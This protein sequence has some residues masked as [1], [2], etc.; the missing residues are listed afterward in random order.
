V[1]CESSNYFSASKN[2]C[3][4]VR[5]NTYIPIKLI[6][7]QPI[8]KPS[9]LQIFNRKLFGGVAADFALLRW[10]LAV[11]VG[12]AITL[13][14]M[15]ETGADTNWREIWDDRYQRFYYFNVRTNE[16]SWVKPAE[17][18]AVKDLPPPSRELALYSPRQDASLYTKRSLLPQDSSAVVETVWDRLAKP[19]VRSRSTPHQREPEPQPAVPA[20]RATPLHARVRS[21]TA[22]RASPSLSSPSASI[23][24]S[25]PSAVDESSSA[26]PAV[27]SRTPVSA[28]AEKAVAAADVWVEFYDRDEHAP[29]FVQVTTRRRSW[30]RPRD[31]VV[32][33]MGGADLCFWLGSV[34]HLV[35]CSHPEPLPPASPRRS[36]STV[37]QVA[38]RAQ[39]AEPRPP[40][41][42]AVDAELRFAPRINASSRRLRRAGVAETTWEWNRQKVQIY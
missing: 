12:H 27:R 16:S 26:S 34:W 35:S 1:H 4:H 25:I 5:H 41:E 33:P 18:D 7:R 6:P 30:Q 2:K 28:P 17:I 9:R 39:S 3:E 32:V 10:F 36:L 13:S 24:A 42:R 40:P 22:S 11:P 15:T 23:P 38:R 21:G 31:A 29:Y 8:F 14:L 20:R 19:M 37:P